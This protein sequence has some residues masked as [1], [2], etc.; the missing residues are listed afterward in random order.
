[1]RLRAVVDPGAQA[2]KAVI[3]LAQAFEDWLRAEEQFLEP[4]A[5]ALAPAEVSAAQHL[6]RR[7]DMSDEVVDLS[8]VWGNVRRVEVAR[9]V[10]IRNADAV[11]R[12][13]KIRHFARITDFH[14]KLDASRTGGIRRVARPPP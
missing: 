9:R 4:L 10:E 6:P 2:A 3:E 5:V 7:S 14:Q 13:A 12:V 11:D 1:S 8:A